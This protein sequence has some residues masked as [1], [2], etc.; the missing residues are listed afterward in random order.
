ML[1]KNADKRETIRYLIIPRHYWDYYL[2]KQKAK[3]RLRLKT[4]LVLSLIGG[5]FTD[6]SR[7]NSPSSKY[8]ETK[9]VVI[10]LFKK[11]I[12]SLQNECQHF[13]NLPKRD[14]CFELEQFI[15]N[16]PGASMKV[17]PSNKVNEVQWKSTIAVN[18]GSERALQNGHSEQDESTSL[19]NAAR[20]L[21]KKLVMQDHSPP[22]R[23]KIQRSIRSALCK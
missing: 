6:V 7:S 11:T 5:I 13:C 17:L 18:I 21:M 16:L 12:L 4:Q 20:G 8:E 23:P 9:E 1:H 15:R 19:Q 3:E 14:F 2:D 22:K 10:K